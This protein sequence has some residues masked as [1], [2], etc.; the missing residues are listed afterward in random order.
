M[1]LAVSA[2]TSAQGRPPTPNVLPVPTHSFASTT[3]TSRRTRGRK[4]ATPWWFVKSDHKRMTLT[5]H[6]S[7]LVA[8]ASATLAMW[9]PTQHPWNSSSF[10]L[11][12][13]SC[14]KIHA[15]PPLTLRTST[16][17]CPCPSQN[18]FASKS[19]IFYKS[20]S[21]STS[22]QVWTVTDGFTVKSTRVAM[23]FYKQ[24]S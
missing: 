14:K 12:V 5:T 1:S 9:V 20:S 13:S 10:S 24:A 23:D 17:T 18:T 19:W 22:S 8:N 4:Y 16:S 3:T 2:K 6:E 11:A 15:L 21:I 7:P